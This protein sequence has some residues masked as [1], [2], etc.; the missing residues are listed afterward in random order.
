MA[1]VKERWDGSREI[2]L[3]T[4][5]ARGLR[6]LLGAGVAVQSVQELGLWQLIELLVSEGV[7]R[8]HEFAV[9]AEV[10]Y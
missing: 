3:S 8:T 4:Q 1:K 5:E 7:E 6:S 2:V 9:I 10:R